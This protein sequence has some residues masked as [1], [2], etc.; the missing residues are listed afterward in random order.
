MWHSEGPTRPVVVIELAARSVLARPRD[1]MVS[2][3]RLGLVE[4]AISSWRGSA[5]AC[6]V[7][8]DGGSGPLQWLPR[9]APAN[10]KSEEV[11]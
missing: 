7:V 8:C 1:Q 10:T 6:L 9:G 11:R 2:S 5:D 4:F 3:D